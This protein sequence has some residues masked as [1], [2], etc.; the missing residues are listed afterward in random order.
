M[1]QNEMLQER[2][3]DAL[4]AVMMYEFAE[5]ENL[6]DL[7]YIQNGN[8]S[9]PLVIDDTLDN[10]VIQ[11]IKK[12]LKKQKKTMCRNTHIKGIRCLAAIIAL[13]AILFTTA[14][15]A[16]E[17]FRVATMNLIITVE[18]EFTRIGLV[19]DTSPAVLID[20]SGHERYF[21]EIDVTWIPEGY[22]RT[23]GEYNYDVVFKNDAGAWIA[24]C[25]FEEGTT[26]NVD[27]EGADEIR[28]IEIDDCRGLFISED[29]FKQYALAHLG[30]GFY[31]DITATSGVSEN[32]LEKVVEG[33]VIR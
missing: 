29:G 23:K 17:E 18:E 1:T 5:N 20:E 25:R 15:A 4:F 28:E 21:D 31:I 24:I 27:T 3:E 11:T 8:N 14:F 32:E 12:E 26:Y 19:K 13:V 6:S 22:I 10:R 30:K 7:K 9:V 2:Y 16:V 33:L